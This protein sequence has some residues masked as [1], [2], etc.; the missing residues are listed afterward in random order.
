VQATELEYGFHDL[1]LS[2]KRE[3]AAK[4]KTAVTFQRC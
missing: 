4:L 2:A 1:K 3:S